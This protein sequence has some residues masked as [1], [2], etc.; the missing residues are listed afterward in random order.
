MGG[1]CAFAEL[2]PPA[3]IAGAEIWLVGDGRCGYLLPDSFRRQSSGAEAV[4]EE[5]GELI[6]VRPFPL[7]ARV[8]VQAPGRGR[9]TL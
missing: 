4:A 9:K 1:A 3:G 7:P 8:P 5:R 6:A 2:S